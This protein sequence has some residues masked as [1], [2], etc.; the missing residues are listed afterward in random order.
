MALGGEPL[1]KVAIPPLGTADGIRKETVV[2][3]AH[4]HGHPTI[5]D[6]AEEYSSS[7]WGTAW[8]RC[9][10]SKRSRH[11]PPDSHDAPEGPI[12]PGAARH[13][14]TERRG[15]APARHRASGLTPALA[16]SAPSPPGCGG[17]QRTVEDVR[18][19]P[20]APRVRSGDRAGVGGEDGGDRGGRR[21]H[22]GH[23]VAPEAALDPDLDW[24]TGRGDLAGEARRPSCRRR[25]K[26]IRTNAFSLITAV[27]SVGEPP[28]VTARTIVL[29][30]RLGRVNENVPDALVSSAA[31]NCV[32]PPV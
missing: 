12:R 19:H 9:P 2:D 18:D 21:A 22:D 23:P 30:V 25:R 13:R 26:L 7:S 1:G 17:E 10:T 15:P 24:R 28:T 11:K 8:V 32:K 4:S 20:I 27:T 3:Q 14:L 31:P 6:M 16:V 29:T 5:P